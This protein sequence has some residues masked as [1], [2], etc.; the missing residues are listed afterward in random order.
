M[1]IWGLDTNC[2]DYFMY[3][4]VCM[5]VMYLVL[6]CFFS[7]LFMKN[8]Y[9]ETFSLNLFNHIFILETIDSGNK[10]FLKSHKLSNSK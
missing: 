3:I 1:I 2:G 4:F 5:Y 6:C 9:D 10:D 7:I 8:F